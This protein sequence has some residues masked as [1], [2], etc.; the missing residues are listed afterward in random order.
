MWSDQ[1]AVNNPEVID[2]I[3]E[4]LDQNSADK[5]LDTTGDETKIKKT[6]KT[7]VEVN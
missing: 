5:S 1:H 6:A 2:D 4:N 3:N 7:Q